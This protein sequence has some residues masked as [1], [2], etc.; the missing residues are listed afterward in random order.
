MGRLTGELTDTAA[1]YI[2]PWP[3]DVRTWDWFEDREKFEAFNVPRHMLY[4]LQLP[5]DV[6]GYVST[7][8]AERTG[9]PL[10]IPVVHTANDKAAEALGSG[11]RDDA[12]GLVSLGTYIA[13]MVGGKEFAAEPQTYFSNFAAE[14]YRY[15][16]ECGGIRRGMWT[17]SWLRDLFGAENALAAAEAG[18]S[19][20]E[21]LN[22]LASGIPAGSDGLLCVLDWLAPPN[23]PFKKGMFIGFDERHGYAHMY[24]AVLEGIAFTMKRN[25]A[26]MTAE[27]DI[28]LR[29]LVISGG[30]SNSDLMMQ[31]FADVFNI[32]VVRNVV[33]NAAGLGAA[34]CVAV[35]CGIYPDFDAASAQMVRREDRFEPNP[36]HAALYEQLSTV[37][38]EIPMHT[39]PI[40]EKIHK[41]LSDI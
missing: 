18:T 40:L 35:A 16:Y 26:A 22:R 32:P 11:L 33:R 41:I 8:F 30:G 36:Q 14:P 17:V 38:A 5:G 28:D 29:T 7:T 10:G 21:R 2:G 9:I 37:A 31:I 39:D 12:T 20:E 23:K 34:I 27:R 4:R 25:M 6:G 1:N 3:M 15:I 13:G 24:R 19:A